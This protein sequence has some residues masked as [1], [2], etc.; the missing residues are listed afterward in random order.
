[1]G[2]ARDGRMWAV[3]VVSGGWLQASRA[4][5]VFNNVCICSNSISIVSSDSMPIFLYII[6]L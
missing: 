4:G 5:P 6:I 1:V 2:H 3:H